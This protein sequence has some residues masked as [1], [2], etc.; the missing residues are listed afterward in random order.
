MQAVLRI[1][2]TCSRISSSAARYLTLWERYEQANRGM[3]LLLLTSME[4]GRMEDL[5]AEI[6]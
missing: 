3:Q 4:I 6:E 2:L 5:M 1:I